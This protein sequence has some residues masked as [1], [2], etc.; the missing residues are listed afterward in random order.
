MLRQTLPEPLRSQLCPQAASARGSCF[1]EKLW[2][3]QGWNLPL[4]R[5]TTPLQRW[6]GDA[7]ELLS[8]LSPSCDP[9]CF[10]P[11]PL[12]T[13][14][15]HHPPAPSL[16]REG[17]DGFEHG[18]AVVAT[19]SPLTPR[20]ETRLCS[21]RPSPNW[22]EVWSRPCGSASP[23]S[24]AFCKDVRSSISLAVSPSSAHAALLVRA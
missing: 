8:Q 22:E 21:H 10:Q 14:L 3:L 23:R 4:W 6:A 15:S 24:A 7:Q 17:R 9:V 5:I 20:E 12:Q 18:L 19:T 1:G 11:T 16:L 2:W 13:S